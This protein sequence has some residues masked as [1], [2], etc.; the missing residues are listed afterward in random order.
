M[1]IKNLEL[2]NKVKEV[3]K[4]AIKPIKAG[5]LKGYS[6]INPV[7]RIKTLTEQFGICG[8]GWYTEIINNWTETGANNEVIYFVKLNLFVNIDNN[9]SKPIQG[10]GGSKLINKW[11][12]RMESNDEALKMAETDALSVACKKIGIAADVYYEN[13]R[14]KYNGSTDPDKIKKNNEI[15]L[16]TNFNEKKTTH[17]ST[18]ITANITEA[19]RKMLFGALNNTVYTTEK[20]DLYVKEKY[21]KSV[22][23]LSKI[24]ASQI[25]SFVKNEIMTTKQL[26]DLKL[27]I[28]EKGYYVIDVKK[29]LHK[30]YGVKEFED[31]TINQYNELLEKIKKAPIKPKTEEKTEEKNNNVTDF[32]LPDPTK[33]FA[34]PDIKPDIKK[35]VEEAKKLFKHITGKNKK[36]TLS[37]K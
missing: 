29:G 26:E 5:T 6:D 30:N 28:T 36:S 12:S 34:Q 1:S 20:L 25:I 37:N 14:T 32:P 15:N 4:N 21:K 2:W 22:L 33:E 27:L 35:D 24:E 18:T 23:E 31:L 10:M 13:D 7:W 9:W 19:Q 3:P 16:G 11:S 8:F 17:N